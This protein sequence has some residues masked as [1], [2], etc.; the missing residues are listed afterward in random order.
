M[1]REIHKYPYNST[2]NEIK[3]FLSDQIGEQVVIITCSNGNFVT[4]R[5]LK[6]QSAVSSNIKDNINNNN[7]LQ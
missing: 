3:I 1:K 4:E 2:E 6:E 5:I 7:G